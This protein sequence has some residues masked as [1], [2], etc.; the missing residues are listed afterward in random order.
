V[1]CYFGKPE[2]L[3]K[4]GWTKPAGDPTANQLML[5]SRQ[6]WSAPRRISEI[7][8]ISNLENLAQM[9]DADTQLLQSRQ[10]VEHAPRQILWPYVSRRRLRVSSEE[11][12]SRTRATPAHPLILRDVRGICVS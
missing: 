7:R 4:K 8:V 9:F 10:I 3:L 1:I 2:F 11:L 6:I 5:P 12:A